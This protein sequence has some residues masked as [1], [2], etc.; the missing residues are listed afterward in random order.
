MG[1]AANFTHSLAL[2]S[3]L[4][5]PGFLR[6]RTSDDFLI[7]VTIAA[8]ALSA[9]VFRPWLGRLIDTWGRRRVLLA[10]GVLNVLFSAAYLTVDQMG[11]WL[12][13]VRI[14]HGLAEGALFSVLFTIAADLVP[15][16]RRAEGMALFGVSGMIPL[17]AAGVIGDQILAA[18][19][20]RDLFGFTIVCAAL[21][22]LASALLRDSTPPRD[23]TAVRR[24]SSRPQPGARFGHFGSRGFSFAFGLASYFAFLKTLVLDRGIG[25]LSAFFTAYTL[26]AVA[27]RLGFGWVPDRFGPRRVL[28]PSMLATA[29]GVLVL[30]SAASDLS[31]LVAGVLCG[32]GHGYT[33]PITSSMVV[34]RAPASERGMALAAF[35][36]LFDLGL[37]VGA[38]IYGLVLERSNYTAMFSVAAGVVTAGAVGF[39]L[40]DPWQAR[41]RRSAA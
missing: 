36:A 25:S 9:I 2:H 38:P 30:A 40:W 41:V 18:G 39:A 3:Y 37:L 7:G 17:S 22:C 6:Q 23:A 35:T 15:P 33:F 26:A 11:A 19:T 14:G 21:G 16:Q 4:H 1:S 10:G 34:E 12:I 27:L 13:F 31:I 28:V 8:M 20:Y 32:V 29:V 5:L 24:S